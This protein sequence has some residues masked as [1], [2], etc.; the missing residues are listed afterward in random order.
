[1]VVAILMVTLL[2]ARMKNIDRE[3]YICISIYIFC[4]TVGG[5][6]MSQIISKSGGLLQYINAI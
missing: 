4:V 5:G 3:M 6:G 2:M 1:M